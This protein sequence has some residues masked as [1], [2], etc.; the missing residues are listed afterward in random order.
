MR[1][2][3]TRNRPEEVENVRM[4]LVRTRAR[5]TEQKRLLEA[6]FRMVQSLY[7]Q[8]LTVLHTVMLKAWTAEVVDRAMKAAMGGAGAKYN[9]ISSGAQKKADG[10]WALE[11]GVIGKQM[12]LM[13]HARD[14]N[15]Q[16]GV[17]ELLR[18][19]NAS[20]MALSAFLSEN[21]RLRDELIQAWAR[22][23]HHYAEGLKTLDLES[24]ALELFRPLVR[25]GQMPK[26]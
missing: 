3:L 15:Y 13:C 1:N 11:F 19:L 4:T 9:I 20:L 24:E 25:P 16:D 22:V 7:Q 6:K 8:F 2:S 5:L 23:F 26:A 10:A 12:V 14:M 17:G 21:A 18:Q